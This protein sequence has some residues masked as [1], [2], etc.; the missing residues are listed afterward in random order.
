[1]AT[2]AR[3]FYDGAA[4]GEGWTDNPVLVRQREFLTRLRHDKSP[5]RVLDLGC[6]H[7]TNTQVLFP[8]PRSVV[9]TGLDLSSRA[10]ADFRKSTGA[11]AV[12]ASGEA[13]PFVDNGFDLVV[14]DDVIEHLVDTDTYAREIRRVLRPGGILTLSTPNLAAWFNRLAL[15]GGIQPAY[16]EVSFERVFGRPG[17]D[18]VGHL[19]LFT[20]KSLLQ[21]LEYHRFEVLEIAGV[22]FDA[23]PQR[24]RRVDGFFAR[25]PRLAGSAVILAQAT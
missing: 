9:V 6:G 14:S 17:A 21:F 8:Q 2:R 18:L 1:M 4:M 7:G 20:T 24:L 12:L 11:P 19:R 3:R 23:L 25:F 5:L 22:R 10:V 15:A 16:T 13:L